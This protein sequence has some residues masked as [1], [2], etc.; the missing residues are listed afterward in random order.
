[1]RGYQAALVDRPYIEVNGHMALVQ[2]VA[3]GDWQTTNVDNYTSG[4]IEHII[5]VDLR[6]GQCEFY[7]CP[8]DALRTEVRERHDQFLASH[9]GRRPRTE[10][11]KQAAIYLQEVR[12]WH[13]GWSRLA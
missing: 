7:I 3:K 12:R 2:V 4:T 5:L 1:M 13:N 6:D 8:G 10:G 11:S 9:G